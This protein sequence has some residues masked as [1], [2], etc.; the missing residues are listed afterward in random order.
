M[1]K[2][3]LPLPTEGFDPTEVAIPWKILTE[4][5]HDV[6]FAT[7]EGSVGSVDDRML[8]GTDL[9]IW[10]RV[11]R[12]RGDAVEAY[13]TMVATE[14]FK[15]PH[16]YAAL[17]ATMFDGL[18]LPGGHDK[19]VREYLESEILQRLVVDFF[20]AKKAVG[21]ICHGVV[22]L[23]RSKIPETGK[24]VLEGYKTTALLKKQETLAYTM[25]RLYL[26]DYYLTYPGMTVEGEV[27]DALEDQSDFIEGPSPMCRD[28]PEK[29]KHGF[30]L[31]D[32]NYVSARWP[33]DAYNFSNA[34]EALLSSGSEK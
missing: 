1:T 18:L 21:A 26:G 13:H 8:N 5:A 16:T 20:K 14:A 12:A 7:P 28:S 29:M 33:G 27:R 11:L 4:A 17:K 15:K 10:K 19:R 34:F 2:I 3:L 25:T 22:V 23:A 30:S 32:R 9:G 24:S 31:T 6:Q